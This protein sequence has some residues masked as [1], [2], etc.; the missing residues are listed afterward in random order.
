MLLTAHEGDQEER[1][2]V[3]LLSVWFM[4]MP[5][6]A[7]LGDQGHQ[8]LISVLDTVSEVPWTKQEVRR[9]KGLHTLHIPRQRQSFAPG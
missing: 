9:T 4:S 3:S 2:A 1:L 5:L 8:L 7:H 6:K